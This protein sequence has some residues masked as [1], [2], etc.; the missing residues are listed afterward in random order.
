MNLEQS[1]PTVAGRAME[2]RVLAAALQAFGERGYHGAS[3][4]FI[5][6]CA[7][8][9]VSNVYNYVSSKD[10]LLVLLLREASKRQFDQVRAAVDGAG[11]APADRLAAAVE[12][13]ARYVVE[14]REELTLSNTEFRYL[15]ERDRADVV[16]QRDRTQGIV[17]GIV[18]D[19]VRAGAFKTPYP[20]DV[21]RSLL[22][23]VANITAW[24]RPDGPLTPAEVAQRH[25][26]FA[27]ALV[28]AV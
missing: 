19:G 18:A 1:A 3:I 12:A 21:A 14:H 24:Y 27:L 13:F 16:E 20:H 2:Q 17:D 11:V 9:S 22:T 6:Q 15:G 10:A 4:R 25:A 7:G 5:A 28:Q 26:Q 8:T 23:M